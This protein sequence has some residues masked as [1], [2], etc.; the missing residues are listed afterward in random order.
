MDSQQ[1]LL[2][3]L[4]RCNTIFVPLDPGQLRFSS[5]F[6]SR[7]TPNDKL[8]KE[9]LE[10]FLD[11]PN[12]DR[13]Q[14]W[15]V[16]VNL[17]QYANVYGRG[18]GF[19]CA[20]QSAESDTRATYTE[21]SKGK[22]LYNF[23]RNIKT[24]P[25]PK[26]AMRIMIYT[27][28]AGPCGLK[29]IEEVLE[30]L[31]LAK[32]I[33]S[34]AV[35]ETLDD[36]SLKTVD[37]AEVAV[38]C[39]K[40][41]GFDLK[42]RHCIIFTEA[43]TKYSDFQ[44]A[45]GRTRRNGKHTGA[46]GAL[47][48]HVE[49]HE[50]IS[51]IADDNLRSQKIR[52]FLNAV[53]AP[54]AL[55][56]S[57]IAWNAFSW[58][59][60]RFV[61]RS[62]IQDIPQSEYVAIKQ[63]LRAKMASSP[64]GKPGFL[65]GS[66][67]LAE[68]LAENQHAT[69]FREYFRGPVILP[70]VAIYYALKFLNFAVFSG[71]TWRGFQEWVYGGQNMGRKMKANFVLQRDKDVDNPFVATTADEAALVKRT[72]ESVQM[73]DMYAALSKVQQAHTP[74]GA[75]CRIV[76]F[77]PELSTALPPCAHNFYPNDTEVNKIKEEL[78]DPT[79]KPTLLHSYQKTIVTQLTNKR[80]S[81]SSQ[82]CVLAMFMGTGK[83]FTALAAVANT[84]DELT[85]VIIACPEHLE[86]NWKKELK[87]ANLERFTK[88]DGSTITPV[89]M[90]YKVM[91]P[92]PESLKDVGL[93]LDECHLAPSEWRAALRHA[94]FRIALSGTPAE[95]V[96]DLIDLVNDVQAKGANTKIKREDFIQIS[97]AL[98]V[99]K[100][101]THM[102]SPVFLLALPALDYLVGSN[103]LLLGTGVFTYA[104][105]AV[106]SLKNYEADHYSWD[107]PRLAEAMS[108]WIYYKGDE[109]E[110]RAHRQDCWAQPPQAAGPASTR[111][112]SRMEAFGRV[113]RRGP[114]ALA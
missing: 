99:A 19:Y 105:T 36:E 81:P 48:N 85:G 86:P 11:A 30:A 14:D 25:E 76:P 26:N 15:E 62:G 67:D 27:S 90:A 17:Q 22:E 3:T 82:G 66:L 93:I 71:Y 38:V 10:F 111:A 107:Y 91:P 79:Y 1:Q 70:T 7:A 40:P 37:N 28:I 8:F 89:F 84:I 68:L 96:A 54:E 97:P 51:N 58:F 46:S 102:F 33:D 98:R 104:A 88:R 114:A 74:Q 72:R 5:E 35:V 43:I 44:Q 9:D 34:F 61:R 108:P 112:A 78:Q 83:S 49:V 80:A 42:D 106:M 100:Y 94:R 13:I 77:A 24:L 69:V 75:I 45:I 29:A 109:N 95:R 32:I 56:Y 12:V 113:L 103:P 92:P 16:K 20:R 73:N 65:Q 23:I 39:N 31:R 18:L 57:V 2:P 47:K 64:Y 50:L 63:K 53:P 41:E 60:R 4:N 55:L 21:T 52:T 59:L 101:M 87:K 6:I 110:N